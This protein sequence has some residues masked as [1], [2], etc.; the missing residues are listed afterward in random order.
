[1]QC[2]VSAAAAQV[3]LFAHRLHRSQAF[4]APVFDH[5]Q[6]G[7]MERK[8]LGGLVTCMQ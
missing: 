5:L 1:M 7:K 2:T 4:L 6:Y 8:G 3:G